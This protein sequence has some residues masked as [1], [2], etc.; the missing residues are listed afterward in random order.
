[1]GSPLA[2]RAPL[3]TECAKCWGTMGRGVLGSQ[4][5][6]ERA[7]GLFLRVPCQAWPGPPGEPS[8]SWAC[9]QHLTDPAAAVVRSS[10]LSVGPTG[11]AGDTGCKSRA[12]DLRPFPR[13]AAH[14]LRPSKRFGSCDFLPSSGAR[15]EACLDHSG[16]RVQRGS[17]LFPS[18]S[19]QGFITWEWGQ[20][21]FT[22]PCI[23]FPLFISTGVSLF[24]SRV[25][26]PVP[27][28]SRPA[29]SLRVCR[30]LT[31]TALCFKLSVR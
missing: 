25:N 29:R 17:P 7:K 9:G 30:C 19:S 6:L 26:S 3:I 14:G 1:M 22:W 21:M 18:A 31:S 12:W 2:M 28:P 16:K 20:D 11:S 4:H 10:D 8:L 23:C 27:R 15:G 13:D 5:P 24:P